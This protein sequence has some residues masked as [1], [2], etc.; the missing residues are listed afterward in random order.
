MSADELHFMTIA[1]VSDLLRSRKLSPV[2]YT[3]TLIDRADESRGQSRGQVFQVSSASPDA[4]S[5]PGQA[6][7]QL[8]SFYEDKEHRNAHL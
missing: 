7:H 8:Q 2:E 5:D 1:K 3:Q 4:E 6:R